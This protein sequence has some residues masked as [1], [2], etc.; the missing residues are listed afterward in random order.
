MGVC[1]TCQK[2]KVH[3]VGSERPCLSHSGLGCCDNTRFLLLVVIMAS[4][5]E[6]LSIE[7]LLKKQREEKEAAAKVRYP[8]SEIFDE[9]S[10]SL[11]STLVA[12]VLD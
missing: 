4:R 12:K 7:S 10:C 3:S 9:V 11:R 2:R 5:A 6:P 1:G 8:R